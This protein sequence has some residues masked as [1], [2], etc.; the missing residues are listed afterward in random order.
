MGTPGAELEELRRGIEILQPVAPEVA[1]RLILHKRRRRCREDHLAAVGECGNAGA[2]VDVDPDVALGRNARGAGMEPHPH[3]DRPRLERLLCGAHSGHGARC[4]G[5][6]HEECVPLRVDLDATLCGERLTQHAAMLGECVGIAAGAELP[7]QPRRTL[8]VRE[9]QRDGS[10]RKG[11]RHA[12][13]IAQVRDR[14]A[15][16]GKTSS[17]RS[18]R[19]TGLKPRRSRIGLDIWPACVTSTGVPRSAASRPRAA[20]SAR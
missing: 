17:R 3:G 6:R 19:D 2:A 16:G 13:S 14:E 12:G 10:R 8:D 5:E 4:R 9:Q 11:S 15:Y 20:T 18:I 7:E 1:E